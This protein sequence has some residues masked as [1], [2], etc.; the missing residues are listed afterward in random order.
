MTIADGGY[1]GTGL[2]MPHRCRAGEEL[3]E[4][5]QEHNRS[6]KQSRIEGLCGTTLRPLTGRLRR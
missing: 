6:H 5:E 3:T 4:W 1:A 2:V